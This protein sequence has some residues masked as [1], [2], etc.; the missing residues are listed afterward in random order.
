MHA[1][2]RRRHAGAQHFLRTQFDRA[3]RKAAKSLPEIVERQSGVNQRAER[4]V[5]RNARK[6]VEVQNPAHGCAN[7]FMLRERAWSGRRDGSHR[8]R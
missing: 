8:S 3:Q 7:S 2:L 1:E 5:A 6:T 4:H